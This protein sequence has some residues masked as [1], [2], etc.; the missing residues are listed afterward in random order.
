MSP[1]QR[2]SRATLSQL[3]QKVNGLQRILPAEQTLERVE[4]AARAVGIT[5][6]ANITGLDRVG[7]PT[8]SAI[9]PKSCDSIS[10][11]TGKGLSAAEA[12][13]GAVM[14]AIERQTILRARPPIVEGSFQELRR[15]QYVLD[16]AS[17]KYPRQP[18]YSERD[19]YSWIVGRELIS[20]RD[21]LVPAKFAGYMWSDVPHR[22]CFVQNTSNG[23]ASGNSLEEAICHAMC[24][25]IE[26]DAWTL[27]ELGGHCL[28]SIRRRVVHGR[29]GESGSDDCQLFAC[30]ALDADPALE[31]FQR[32][33]L[34]PVLHDITTD[35]GV[36]TVFAA[37]SDESI[38]GMP[39]VHCG[40]G[41]HPDAR[42]AARRALTEAAQS[43]CV[44]IQGIRED[45]VA[46]G[47]T[48]TRFNLHTRRISTLNR[49]SWFLDRSAERRTISALPSVT[50]DKI[51]ADVDFMLGRLRD[52][53]I[54]EVIVVDFSPH[55]AP[56]AV[57]RVI[58]PQLEAW[59]ISHGPV[60]KRA[61]E[62]W[63]SRA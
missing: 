24:E 30:I 32:A 5:R 15:E 33:N 42:V 48:T 6:V 12:K 47:S 56:F 1:Q 22:S 35:L 11:Y 19:I 17:L 58:I 9:V 26:R 43:R 49:H 36:P 23:M 51:K 41:A 13:A 28:P 4:Y 38:C 29:G 62:F 7:L 34:E 37:V 39:M 63:C 18:D 20:D 27:A 14:E 44:D 55:G 25:L 16:P 21:I 31:L 8:Y 60:G 53:D 59:V 45:I 46:A 50:H 3:S 40:L 61:L 57:V 10:V 52:S 2:R 54:S